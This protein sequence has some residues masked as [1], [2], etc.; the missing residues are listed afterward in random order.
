MVL[1]VGVVIL[2]HNIEY[3]TWVGYGNLRLLGIGG[4][5]GV[6]LREGCRKDTPNTICVQLQRTSNLK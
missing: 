2:D 6:V 3:G 4:C 1:V 5:D